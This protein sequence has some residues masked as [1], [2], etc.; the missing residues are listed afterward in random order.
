MN[1][2]IYYAGSILK[3]TVTFGVPKV[4]LL[5]VVNKKWIKLDLIVIYWL[6]TRQSVTKLTAYAKPSKLEWRHY[7]HQLNYF[8]FNSFSSF[9]LSKIRQPF[10]RGNLLEISS[11]ITTKIFLIYFS[12]WFLLDQFIF[13]N[14]SVVWWSI[15]YSELQFNWNHLQFCYCTSFTA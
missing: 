3:L 11:S 14:Q 2:V 1:F 6:I 8:I 9:S 15:S 10:T 7:V 5:I 12:Y 4:K 13:V